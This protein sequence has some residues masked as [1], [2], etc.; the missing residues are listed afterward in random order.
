V[1]AFAS[2]RVTDDDSEFASLGWAVDHAAELGAQPEQLVVAGEHA[3]GAHAARLAVRARDNGWPTVCRQ[4]LVYPTFTHTCPMPL[5][6]TDV[7][8]A[9]VISSNTRID[10]GTA[11]AER[12]RASAIEVDVL[13]HS[14]PVLP[15]HDELWTALARRA[16]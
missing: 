6:L 7:A 12:L 1:L 9:T 5:L 10:D 16:R 13:R 2:A 4:V 3:A 15:G 11:Y 8:P 14:R